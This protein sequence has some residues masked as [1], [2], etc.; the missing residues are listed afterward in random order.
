MSVHTAPRPN[1]MIQERR[2]VSRKD[3]DFWPTPDWA[4]A[5]WATAAVLDRENLP[6]R[7]WEPACGD[8]AMA[9]VLEGRGYRVEATDRSKSNLLSEMNAPRKLVGLGY[10]GPHR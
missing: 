4:T 10:C 3:A 8:G 7:V 6:G 2:V 5:D 1:R 9:R